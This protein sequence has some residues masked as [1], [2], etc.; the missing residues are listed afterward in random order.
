MTSTATTMVQQQ[1]RLFVCTFGLYCDQHT[2]KCTPVRNVGSPCSSWD[3]CVDGTFCALGREQCVAAQ[4]LGASCNNLAADGPFCGSGAFCND[5]NV[6]AASL[7]DGAACGGAV[8]CTSTCMN[9]R[10]VPNPSVDQVV[11]RAL[12]PPSM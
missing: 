5:M 11:F 12:C 2:A 3:M 9:G 4:A 6:C 8:P 10:C 7:P 1:P